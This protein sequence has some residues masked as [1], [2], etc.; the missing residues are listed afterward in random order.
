MSFQKQ[1]AWLYAIPTV[2]YLIISVMLIDVE[3]FYKLT[4]DEHRS[5]ITFL[6]FGL[7]ELDN[8]TL[9]YRMN[10]E[11]S[12]IYYHSVFNL[13]TKMINQK[14]KNTFKRMQMRVSSLLR[15]NPSTRYIVK[16]FFKKL[17]WLLVKIHK[18]FFIK[19]WI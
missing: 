7:L 2:I 4:W 10:V 18:F 16:L 8:N 13:N 6:L 17:H 9:E 15:N 3:K 11:T 14:K 12:W 5:S 19:I 1:Y